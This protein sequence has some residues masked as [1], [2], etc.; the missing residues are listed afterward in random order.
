MGV[1]PHT[2]RYLVPPYWVGLGFFSPAPPHPHAAGPHCTAHSTD[3]IPRLLG[4]S[5]HFSP[6]LPPTPT[7][8][9][10]HHQLEPY[11]TSPENGPTPGN[12]TDSMVP[13][14]FSSCLSAFVSFKV[15]IWGAVDLEGTILGIWDANR[16]A[17][18]Y[19][20]RTSSLSWS[21][22]NLLHPG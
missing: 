9:T 19:L 10:L 20:W 1:L 18:P 8:W 7:F 15:G 22:S 2:G 4:H 21:V 13:Q 6:L 3:A 17:S 5:L 14:R 11:R 12:F 16:W